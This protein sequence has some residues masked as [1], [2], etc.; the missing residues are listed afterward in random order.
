[1]DHKAEN[2]HHSVR[3]GSHGH[4]SH[5]PDW[6]SRMARL[7]DLGR[8]E[9]QVSEAELARIL[10]L[11]GDEDMLDLGSGTGFYTDRMATL[12][13]GVVYALEVVPAMLEYHRE[14]GI[15]DNVRLI[16]G[17]MTALAQNVADDPHQSDSLGPEMVDVAIT[18]ATWHEIDGHLDVSGL[19]D[20]LRPRGRLIVIDW[21]KNPA[22][23]DHGPPEEV[24][25]SASDVA[26]ALQPHL[27]VTKVEDLGPCM[28]AVTAK[29]A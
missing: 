5:N 7:D 15:P 10:A 14:R 13:T 21:R 22:T 16:Q 19:A 6:A 2:Q 20:L 25:Y 26:A 1:M 12:T 18:I 23:W 24:R 28:F 9:S 4:S 17:D 27:A 3:A 11:R 8:L 29:R